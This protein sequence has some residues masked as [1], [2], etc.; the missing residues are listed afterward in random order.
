[1][2]EPEPTPSPGAGEPNPMPEPPAVPE[3]VFVDPFDP[4]A[5]VQQATSTG[6][7]T[8]SPT[9]V[10]EL[11]GFVYYPAQGGQWLELWT[12]GSSSGEQW[13]RQGEGHPTHYH[14]GFVYSGVRTGGAG[15]IRIDVNTKQMQVLNRDGDIP[16]PQDM[17][18]FS[19]DS[20]FVSS[21]PGNS[22]G[23]YRLHPDNSVDKVWDGDV[24]GIQLSPD[25]RRLYI[26]AGA[27]VEVFSVDADGA[28][29]EKRSFYSKS[30][31]NG[32]GVDSQGNVIVG[33]SDIHAVNIDGDRV[34]ELS[35]SGVNFAYGGADNKTLFITQPDR[36]SWV[37][38]RVP[39][40]ECNGLEPLK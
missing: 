21:W 22:P 3:P 14:Q 25:C 33:G 17:D 1:M 6:V 12:V 7:N 10:P 18:R 4:D 28:L 37:R 39:G 8:E 19:D 40:A 2:P 24:N 5:Q 15:V 38:T 32:I 20:I 9:W 34:G 36:T 31:V 27:G 13:F 11:N 29:S 35:T 16:R 30:G 26:V 23:I